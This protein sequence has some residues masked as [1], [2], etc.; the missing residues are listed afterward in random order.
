MEGDALGY[1]IAWVA[2]AA[3]AWSLV[4]LAVAWVVV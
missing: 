1:V 3:G 4:T 2:A